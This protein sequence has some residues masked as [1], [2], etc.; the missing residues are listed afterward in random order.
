MNSEEEIYNKALDQW[1]YD[2]QADM[3]IEEMS[4]LTKAILK[5]R[6]KPH[7]D[8]A[9]DIAEELADVTI[10]LRQLEI[11]MTRS[12]PIFNKWKC[13]HMHEKLNRVK[14]ML[15]NDT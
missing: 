9:L 3:V 5:Y 12:Y 4:E 6:R 2:A 13:Q 1:G 15:E 11:M 7:K 10:M 8:R 14:S